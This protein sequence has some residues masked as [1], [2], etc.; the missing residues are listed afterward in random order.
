MDNY[1]YIKWFTEIDKHDIPIVGGKEQILG[2]DSKT[3]K[4]AT[5]I[6]ITAEAYMDFVQYAELDEVIRALMYGLD[7]EDPSLLTYVS[8]EIQNKIVN[9]YT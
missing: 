7:E 9:R 8:E 2:I 4:C 6:C 1:K 5:R 3:I